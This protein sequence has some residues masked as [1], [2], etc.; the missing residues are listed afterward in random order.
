MS[1]VPFSCIV[2]TMYVYKWFHGSNC[3]NHTATMWMWLKGTLSC[4][5][6]VINTLN[7]G[8]QQCNN[9]F[10][11]S[12]AGGPVPGGFGSYRYQMDC[13][14]QRERE[15][16]IQCC[17]AKGPTCLGVGNQSLRTGM[18]TSPEGSILTPKAMQCAIALRRLQNNN[19]HLN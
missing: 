18:W 17:I 15:S 6:F 8:N 5:G 16:G 2:H 1:R 4:F 13:S 11:L 3:F 10:H 14:M 12:A 9:L 7:A 19:H